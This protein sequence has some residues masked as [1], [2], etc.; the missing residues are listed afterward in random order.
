M[1]KIKI[2]ILLVS[3]SILDD[4]K[5]SQKCDFW[6]EISK[7]VTSVVSHSEVS[8]ESPTS[9]QH[10][11]YVTTDATPDNCKQSVTEAIASMLPEG[12]DIKNIIV[13]VSLENQGASGGS[14]MDK[15]A[16]L[17]KSKLSESEKPNDKEMEVGEV[18]EKKDN[19]VAAVEKEEPAASDTKEKENKNSKPPRTQALQD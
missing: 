19:E 17:A 3:S 4:F 16:S 9:F 13:S 1:K 8:E 10:H 6:E 14:I 2:S 11:F 5:S 7:K 12:I 18:S 15:L